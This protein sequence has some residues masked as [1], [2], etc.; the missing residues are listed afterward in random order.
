MTGARTLADYL[1]AMCALPAASA[2]GAGNCGENVDRADG[3]CAVV[4]YCVG[5]AG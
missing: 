4:A 3:S 1:D 2:I 5:V